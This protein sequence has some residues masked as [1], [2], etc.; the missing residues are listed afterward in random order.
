VPAQ[1]SFGTWALSII[2]DSKGLRTDLDKLELQTAKDASKIEKTFSS[3]FNAGIDKAREGMGG[4]ADFVGQKAGTITAY[5]TSP[6]AGVAALG[7]AVGAFLVSAIHEAELFDRSFNQVRL[8]LLGTGTNVADLQEQLLELT[9]SMATA[10]EKAGGL[11]LA[12]SKG[13]KSDEALKL[14]EIASQLSRV[15]GVDLNTATE[16]LTE[17]LRAYG[18]GVQD[19]D[20]VSNILLS[21][22]QK[23]GG[24]QGVGNMIAGLGRIIPIA[25]ELHIPL[26]Q[27][28]AAL[29][30]M[31]QQGIEGSRAAM[32][33]AMILQRVTTEAQKFRDAG[34]DIAKVAET[35]GIPGVLRAIREV[36]GGT[37]EDLKAM[38]IESRT[39]GVMLALAGEG[40]GRFREN[41]EAAGKLSL[42]KLAQETDTLT[43]SQMN[44][45]TAWEDFKVAVGTNAIPLLALLTEAAANMI[46]IATGQ[47]VAPGI[48]PTGGM[49]APGVYAPGPMHPAQAAPALAA[50]PTRAALYPGTAGES[51]HPT[52]AMQEAIAA[53]ETMSVAERTANV[54]RLE[55]ENKFAAEVAKIREDDAIHAISLDKQVAETRK[56]SEVELI[57]FDRRTMETRL[58]FEDR[59]RK[60]RLETI[61]LE[62]AQLRETIPEEK[63]QLE[64]LAHEREKLELEA[65]TAHEAAAKQRQLLDQKTDVAAQKLDDQLFEHRKKLEV[66]GLREEIDRLQQRVN[67][68]RGS[69]Q[70]QMKTE[71]DLYAKKKELRDKERAE[72]ATMTEKALAE[73]EKEQPGQAFTPEDIARKTKE[74]TAKNVE[75]AQRWQQGYAMAPEDIRQAVRAPGEVEQYARNLQQ[76][77]SLQNLQ[78]GAMNITLP[79]GMTGPDLGI[80]GWGMAQI[81]QEHFGA[82][83]AGPV[84]PWVAAGGTPV[85]TGIPAG[86]SD[87][88]TEAERMVDRSLERMNI[89]FKSFKPVIAVSVQATDGG[90][91]QARALDEENRRANGRW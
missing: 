30:T 78:Q 3:G 23:A 35:Q 28:T 74:M 9:P 71:E 87:G 7:V 39:L 67:A 40:A 89:K 49:A 57:E 65:T 33:L 42:S 10:S 34:V 54:A 76:Y 45:N 47:P 2:A 68:H 63:K 46:K 15:T 14:L 52:A 53:Q 73:L 5:L 20:R 38:G 85:T 84:N 18:L 37:N 79:R 17:T 43:K 31:Q 91:S 59:R 80:G 8:Q 58:G 24:P 36:S 29:V 64:D 44:L 48:R 1:E 21:T 4:L 13:F 86:V 32:A 41:L 66:V 81:L 11:G 6:M 27:V 26:E 50:A 56:A 72:N 25:N 55:R 90:D 22:L 51:E 70:E 19:A 12:L 16:L 75:L 60:A 62:M 88:L 77:G 82:P 83:K 69:V 61:K